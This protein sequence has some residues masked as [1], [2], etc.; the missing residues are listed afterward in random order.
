MIKFE[1]KENG[2]Y[3]YLSIERD[4]FDDY[5][6]CVLRGG[7]HHRRIVRQFVHVDNQAIQKEIQRLSRLRLQRGYTLVN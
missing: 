5:I 3:Y 7:R 6:L 2:R 4:L 1:N